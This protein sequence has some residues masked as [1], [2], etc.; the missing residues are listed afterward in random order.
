METYFL[1]T[2]SHYFM[3]EPIPS[4]N[5]HLQQSLNAFFSL[6]L[7]FCTPL[8]M[9]ESIRQRLEQQ[10]AL[11]DHERQDILNELNALQEMVLPL[12]QSMLELYSLL[13]QE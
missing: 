10:E 13:T 5:H 11:A 4:P 7:R 8:Y 3:T 2:Y 1:L 12:A 9:L 6:S